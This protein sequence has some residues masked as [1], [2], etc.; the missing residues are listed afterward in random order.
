MLSLV[1]RACSTSIEH[2]AE[3]KLSRHVPNGNM[4]DLFWNFSLAFSS[5][6]SEISE[7]ASLQVATEEPNKGF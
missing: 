1:E 4:F 6:E 5:I 7:Q 2:G 3:L